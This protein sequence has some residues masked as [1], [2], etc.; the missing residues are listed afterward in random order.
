MDVEQEHV[1]A[2]ALISGSDSL[3]AIL[4][5]ETFI[6]IYIIDVPAIVAVIKFSRFHLLIAF[7]TYSLSGTCRIMKK[8]F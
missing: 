1:T 7:S 4:F 6:F 3:Q 8:K 5:T 2:T